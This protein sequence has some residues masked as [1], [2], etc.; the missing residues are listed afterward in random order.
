[1]LRVLALAL[2]TLI[3]VG[4]SGYFD[5]PVK[6]QALAPE[7]AMAAA[8]SKD[9]KLAVVSSVESGI[10]VWDL[11]THEQKFHWSLR[12][13]E[14]VNLVYEVAIA[15]DN[16]HALTTDQKTFA[17]WDLQRGEPTGFWRIDESNVRAIAVANLGRAILVGRSNGK[18]MFMEPNTGRRLEF[19]GHSEKINSVAL[20]PNGKYALTGGNDYLAYLWDTDTGQ[21]VH[22]F[23]M[24]HRVSKVALD[25][26]GQYG[27][28]ADSMDNAIIWDLRTGREI[29]R[30]QYFQRQKIFSSVRF[31]KNGA[32]ILTG[33][34]TRE[35]N[36][37]DTHTGQNLKVWRVTPRKHSQPMS[38]VVY[39]AVFLSGNQ[40]LSISSA[41]FA[42][43][44][45]Y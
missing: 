20:S 34:P 19:L 30:L 8:L 45:S 7:G 31:S 23:S 39:D 17:L 37:W 3:T 40:V 25:A 38:A 41:G 4:C 43:V 36:L 24:P 13:E 29:S 42:E 1:M 44:W 6:K 18:V 14:A 11:T 22:Q 21:V 33:S 32:Q 2:L 16:S 35:L 15:W 5:D 12:G 28:T 10:N 26:N 9:G 27:F